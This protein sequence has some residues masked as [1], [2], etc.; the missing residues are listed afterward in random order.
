MAI[1][2]RGTYREIL[3]SPDRQGA[4]GRMVVGV[5]DDMASPSLKSN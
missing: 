3:D 5:R 2:G 4:E 1:M